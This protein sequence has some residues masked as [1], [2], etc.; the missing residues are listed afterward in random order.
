MLKYFESYISN[1]EKGECWASHSRGQ[2]GRLPPPGTYPGR[3]ID[4]VG[5]LRTLSGDWEK[6]GKLQKQ[7]FGI[8]WP[9]LPKPQRV[10]VKRFHELLN[11]SLLPRV[12]AQRICDLY[13]DDY[14]CF[15][16]PVPAVCSIDCAAEPTMDN[17]LLAPH[18]KAA[19]TTKLQESLQPPQVDT[20]RR[21]RR[22]KPKPK[23]VVKQPIPVRKP[24]PQ[25]SD[26]EKEAELSRWKG[27]GGYARAVAFNTCVYSYHPVSTPPMPLISDGFRVVYWL[28][29]K[30]GSSTMREGIKPFYGPEAANNDRWRQEYTWVTV[31]RDP[32]ERSVSSFWEEGKA[33]K[34]NDFHGF[35]LASVAKAKAESADDRKRVF[36]WFESFISNLEKQQ[37]W[38]FHSRGQWGRL[39]KPGTYPGRSIDFVA[40]LHTL[41][42]EWEEIAAY[43]HAKFNVTLP[44]LPKAA[45][46]NND[47]F[48]KLLNVSTLPRSLAQRI[49]NLY[50]DDYCCFKLP[51]P[52]VCTVEC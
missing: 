36:G 10:N 4:F 45:R 20:S 9:S 12:L 18:A 30:S 26:S 6:L 35:T 39:P 21:R 34:Y 27:S 28:L 48:H 43:Q 19:P 47:N 51:V 3:V 14:C 13:R 50:R 17:P 37:C 32:L 5:D 23:M 22:R 33:C 11:V 31:V 49:C 2:R 15:K 7:N 40:N 52:D 41:A 46:V 25:L 44:F 8:E 24:L 29:S 38:G 42:P 1:L 16:L